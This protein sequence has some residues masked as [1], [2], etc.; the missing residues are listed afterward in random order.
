MLEPETHA[1]LLAGFG[2]LGVVVRRRC[3]STSQ[4]NYKLNPQQELQLLFYIYDQPVPV[5]PARA[6]KY[7]IMLINSLFRPLLMLKSVI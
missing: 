2:I 4:S 6:I 3:L 5:Q 1:V 7:D